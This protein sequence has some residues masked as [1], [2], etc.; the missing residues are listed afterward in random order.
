MCGTIKFNIKGGNCVNVKIEENIIKG[1]IHTI[2][3]DLSNHLPKFYGRIEFNI[4]NGKFINAN[5]IQGVK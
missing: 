2:G 3:Q 4:Q 5:I 1:Q